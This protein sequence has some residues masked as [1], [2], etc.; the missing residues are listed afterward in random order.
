M[1]EGLLRAA[2]W[3]RRWAA[4]SAHAA[5]GRAEAIVERAALTREEQR[6]LEAHYGALALQALARALSA[7]ADRE[8]TDP[9]V[10]FDAPT[11]VRR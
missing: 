8:D 6:M 10:E 1:T 7:E 2:A 5:G 4:T 3:A 9:D 11:P